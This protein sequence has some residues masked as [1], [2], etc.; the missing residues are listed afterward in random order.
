MFHILPQKSPA[1]VFMIALALVGLTSWASPVYSQAS[2]P[3][4]AAIERSIFLTPSSPTDSVTNNTLLTGHRDWSFLMFNHDPVTTFTNPTITVNSDF[5]NMTGTLFPQNVG[6]VAIIFPFLATAPT[7]TLP[8]N[9]Q[10]NQNFAFTSI[11]G[12]A[13]PGFDSSRSVSPLVIAPGGGTQVLTVKITLI[14]PRYAGSLNMNVNVG[15]ECLSATQPNNLDA[16]EQVTFTNCNP[17]GGGMGL[18]AVQLNKEYVFKF[19]LHVPNTGSTSVAS[20]PGLSVQSNTFQVPGV[21]QGAF[22]TI[23]DDLL[24][25]V[26]VGGSATFAVD[27][28]VEWHPRLDDSFIVNYPF[29][30]TTVTDTTPPA[31]TVPA[32]ITAEAT[33]SSGALVTFAASA[34]DDIDGSVP[35][36]CSPASGSTFHLGATNVSCSASD[37]AGNAASASFTVTVQDTTPPTIDCPSNMI[38]YQ[39]SAYGAIA[40]FAP[41]ASDTVSAVRTSCTPASGSNFPLGTTSVQCTATDASGNKSSCSFTVTVIP[42][43]ST[44]GVKSTDGGSIP[45]PGGIGTFGIVAM[46]SSTGLAQG[47]VEYQDH[48]TGMNIKSTVLTAIVVTGTHARIFGKATINGSGSYD[49]VVDVDDLGEPG[50]GVDKFG[51]QLSD[52]YTAGP[53]R[54]TAG[55]IQVHQ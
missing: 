44:V 14:D 22:V 29:V 10:M 53:A 18:N 19:S 39:S 7:Q 51:I 41:T 47:R 35:V 11:Q 20:K 26:G 37:Q 45:I 1:R 34:V 43:T 32:N 31:I 25:S 40:N 12:T 48:V 6:P 46:G 21:A 52:G 16:G 5:A 49:F 38:V 42:P 50:I 13:T 17:F 33:S 24:G 8:V 9:S 3:I 54:L 27:Q 23:P 30:Y 36:T 2:G 15:G 4:D 28:A 55:N